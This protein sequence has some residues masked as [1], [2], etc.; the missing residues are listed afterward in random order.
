MGFASMQYSQDYHHLLLDINF[1]I[2]T[3]QISKNNVTE[4]FLEKSNTTH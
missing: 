3:N 1:N 4:N 2:T